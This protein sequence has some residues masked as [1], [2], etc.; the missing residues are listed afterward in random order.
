MQTLLADASAA[1]APADVVGRR[2]D[3]RCSP[4]RGAGPFRGGRD[5]QRESR[6]DGRARDRS[7]LLH[8]LLPGPARPGPIPR[9][10]SG[11]PVWPIGTVDSLVHDDQYVVVAIARRDR[12][13]GI[14]SD[15]EP[16]DH[17]S[18]LRE[19]VLRDDDPIISP[20]AGPASPY[21]VRGVF[22]VVSGRRLALATIEVG[23][24]QLRA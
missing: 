18:E 1:I 6:P 11:A 15:L 22:R 16:D 2:D 20:V 9:S 3:H 23:E 19:E 14:G 5:R 13:A 21:V 4:H 12:Y 24:P 8:Q 10:G 17:D 7:A